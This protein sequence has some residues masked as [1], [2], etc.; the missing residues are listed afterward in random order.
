MFF[1]KVALKEFLKTFVVFGL[2]I[3]LADILIGELVC[4]SF[5]GS[6]LWP[7]ACLSVLWFTSV[8][9]FVDAIRRAQP[10]N[11]PL[12]KA[13]VSAKAEQERRQYAEATR[14]V[15]SKE[16]MALRAQRVADIR[17]CLTD[18]GY[19]WDWA[20]TSTVNRIY[21]YK[22]VEKAYH[23]TLSLD[24]NDR[25]PHIVV[26]IE[27]HSVEFLNEPYLNAM[28]EKAELLNAPVMEF[29]AAI[30]DG[31][32]SWSK[33]PNDLTVSSKA[34]GFKNCHAVLK[35]AAD[36]SITSMLVDLP[37]GE[38]KRVMKAKGAKT[39]AGAA[40][41]TAGAKKASATG[42]KPAAKGTRREPGVEGAE[43]VGNDLSKTIILP[44]SKP[45]A[46]PADISPD[47]EFEGL[48]LLSPMEDPPIDDG[49]ARRNAEQIAGDI[50]T[51]LADLAMSAEAE[52]EDSIVVEWPEGIQ[53]Q[54]EAEFLGA[55]LT[56]HNTYSK[57]EVNA[58]KKTL[59]LFLA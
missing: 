8:G 19:T 14:P 11:D 56:S 18:S 21:L 23:A 12:V 54:R 4:R 6:L 10:K 43:R 28:K 29:F 50:N 37:N 16:T 45:E 55:S 33:Y 27:G 47:D 51:M 24:D 13:L 42:S 57:C 26:E 20:D 22:S 40:K 5:L 52:G 59:T 58:E 39:D 9:P 30:P 15:V 34:R 3:G 25:I 17:A 32:W 35:R 38:K 53:T 41:T 7:I 1:P 31:V 46:A 48:T 44:T 2:I 36:G 49:I